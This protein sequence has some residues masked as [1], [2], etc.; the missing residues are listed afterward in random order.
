MA[1]QIGHI[2]L[3]NPILM[4]PMAGVTDRVFRALVARHGAGLTFSEMVSA[5]SIIYNNQ[6][7]HRLL[8]NDTAVRP[9]AV[10]FFGSEPEVLAA[11]IRRLDELHGGFAPYDI[12]DINMG[13]PMPK[14]VK[15]GEGAALANDPLLAGRLVAAAV[16]ASSRP[17]TVKVRKGF[18][19]ARINAA[20]MARIAQ[21]SGASCVTVHG[22]TRD[23]YYTGEA[24]WQAIADVKAAVRIPVIGNGDIF[25]PETAVQRLTNGDVDGIMIAR[26]AYGNPWLFSRTLAA[27]ATGEVPPPPDRAEVIATALSHLRE[28]TALYGDVRAM[29]KHLSWYTKGMHGSAELR[30]AINH[31]ETEAGMIA[32]LQRLL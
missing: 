17:V 23:Q 14:I 29:R 30:R 9:W 6:N 18:T 32:L 10:Q 20:Q 11:A 21:E 1:M 15:N 31:T 4:A 7:T 3:P 12:V 8:E 25:S 27:L 24:D 26:G 19:P 13:C 16:S 2:T 5:K 22:R 28:A